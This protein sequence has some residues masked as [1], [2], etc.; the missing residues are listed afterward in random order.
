M[1]FIMLIGINEIRIV[2]LLVVLLLYILK[3]LI[4]FLC[5]K[6]LEGKLSIGFNCDYI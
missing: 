4:F 6:S 1:F 5:Y 2:F 3:V